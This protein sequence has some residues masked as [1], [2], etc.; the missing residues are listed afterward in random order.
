[1]RL[2][3]LDATPVPE[4]SSAVEALRH[5]VELASLA[6]EAGYLRYW[7][8]ELH[9]SPMQAGSTP[10][11]A[12]A[13]VAAGTRRIRVGSG[14]VLLNHRSAFRTAETFGQLHAMFPGRI[15]LGMGRATAGPVIDAALQIHPTRP[16]VAV[17]HE[18]QIGAVLAW[19]DQG[20]PADHPFS[21]VSFMTGVDGRPEPWLLGSTRSSAVLAA[22]FGLRYA[23]AGFLNPPGAAPA[24]QAYRE[25]F[26]PSGRPTGTPEP[27]SLLALNVA[28]A[29]TETEARRL[30]ASA[31]LVYQEAARGRRLPKVPSAE[32]AV[33]ELGLP[34]ET[35]Y[36]GVLVVPTLSGTPERLRDLLERI[37]ADTGV[38]ELMIQD[39]IA[40]PDARRH[41]YALLGQAF[42]LVPAPIP[43]IRDDCHG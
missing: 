9:G 34:T 37:A 19:L 39:L 2:S 32:T 15:D 14:A 25:Q 41:S 42:A 4:G 43:A 30:R 6:D 28:C 21:A 36:S 3:I 38:D 18:D 7:V 8:T 16:R 23:F 40:D 22:R 33:R 26:R 11:V 29:D 35:G 13:R 31:E 20:F 17:D 5:S 27:H 10:E 24:L 12:I 1:M